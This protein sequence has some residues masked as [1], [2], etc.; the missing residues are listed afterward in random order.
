MKIR[1]C[2]VG[3]LMTNCILI[4]NEE[5]GEILITDPGDNAGR[6]VKAVKDA[7]GKPVAILLT[8]AHNDHT[9]AV[10]EL[11]RIYDGIPVYIGEHETDLLSD[12]ERSNP[13]GESTGITADVTVQEG[14]VLELAGLS[15]KVLHTP[16]HTAGSV[17]YYF[18]KEKVLI[19]GDT[20]FFRGYGRTDLDTGS[21]EEMD[22]SLERLFTE[23]LG[24]VVVFP[25]HGRKTTIG[26][27]RTVYGF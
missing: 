21:P 14:Q 8:H 19:A 18:E 13:F 26:S 27:E 3:E 7:G 16:G 15:M 23:L 25:G 20:L 22:K 1:I 4:Q 5:T 2:V 9:G 17:C 10:E 11:R 12:G 6:I 24:D